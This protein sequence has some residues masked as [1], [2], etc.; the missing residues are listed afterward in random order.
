MYVSELSILFSCHNYYLLHPKDGKGTVFT[1]VCLSTG[2]V[3]HGLW[4]QVPSL[5]SGPRSFFWGGVYPMVSG[6]VSL[7]W[8]LAL[9]RGV[10]PSP[11]T[12]PAQNP[13]WGY[14]V[15]AGGYPNLG[16]D[17]PNRTRGTPQTGGTP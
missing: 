15:L 16:K 5:V 2:W 11:F 6:P 8:S 9:S 3:S 4:S 14:P 17:T 7:P 1:G 13:V 12:G 10:Y